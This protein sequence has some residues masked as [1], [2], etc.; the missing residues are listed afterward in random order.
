MGA[1]LEH[2]QWTEL[3]GVNEY[4][5]VI[6]SLLVVAFLLLV[7]LRVRSQSTNN[8]SLVPSPKFSLTNLCLLYTSPRP[9]D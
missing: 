8:S 6:G 2:A 7:S 9:R 3:I 1:A 4:D 5:H